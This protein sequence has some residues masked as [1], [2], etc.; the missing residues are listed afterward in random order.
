MRRLLRPSNDDYV[1]WQR[2]PQLTYS[3]Q[4]SPNPGPIPGVSK[5]H[6]AHSDR[7]LLREG[8][9]ITI[10]PFLTTGATLAVEDI[11]GWTL[12]SPDGSRGAQFEH[13]LIITR[14]RPIVVT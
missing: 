9:V 13:T 6:I 1:C 11:D 3:G 4:S 14:G 2:F 8:L 10:E 12:R 5:S 7:T